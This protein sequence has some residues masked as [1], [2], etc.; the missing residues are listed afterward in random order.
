MTESLHRPAVK[1][2]PAQSAPVARGHVR[3]SWAL[4]RHRFAPHVD[5][6]LELQRVAGNAAVVELIEGKVATNQSTTTTAVPEK[7]PSRLAGDPAEADTAKPAPLA[8]ALGAA[9]GGPAAAAGAAAHGV[10][11]AG[12]KALG[13]EV[14]HGVG[15]AAGLGTA[16]GQGVAGVGAEVAGAAAPVGAAGA[17]GGVKGGEG[18]KAG[19][20]S[21]ASAPSMTG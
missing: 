12:A 18:G 4:S 11:V 5:D 2:V 19:G 8:S 10:A 17:V 21:I 13:G 20:P 14:A 9:S 16:A 7:E 6:L 15:A 1:N 3:L